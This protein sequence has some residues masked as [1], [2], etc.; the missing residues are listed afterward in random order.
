M[1]A[2]RRH[3]VRKSNK[4]QVVHINKDHKEPSARSRKLDRT[5][6]EVGTRGARG[7]GLYGPI[8]HIFPCLNIHLVDRVAVFVVLLPLYLHFLF[9]LAS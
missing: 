1:P 7:T 8:P 4:G 3:L 9:N 5:P 6:H 2:V